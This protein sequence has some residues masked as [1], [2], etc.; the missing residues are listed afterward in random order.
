MSNS[1]DKNFILGV[2]G[3]MGPM[4]GVEFQKRLI[5]NTPATRDNDHIKVISFTNPHIDDRTT[6]IKNGGCFATEVIKSIKVIEEAGAKT[7]VMMCNT[8]HSKFDKISNAV[9][10][11]LINIIQETVN[12]IS[13]KFI[14]CQNVGIL[15]TD[16][17]IMSKLYQNELQ[18]KNISTIILN[19]EDQ[20]VLMELIYGTNGIKSGFVNNLLNKF[21]VQEMI[22]KLKNA[23]AELVILG[24]TEL[25]LL[26]VDDN[27]VVDPLTVVSQKVVSLASCIR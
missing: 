1:I 12:Y 20:T 27:Q 5:E 18:Q 6:C 8:A 3:G 17:T 4:A 15:A 7:A 19:K 24:C 10:I 11:P 16:G 25:S 23:G 14:N 21:V 13:D 2:L 22:M 9:N 26:G